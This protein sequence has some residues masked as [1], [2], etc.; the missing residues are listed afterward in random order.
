MTNQEK[1][2]TGNCNSLPGNEGPNC[3]LSSEYYYYLQWWWNG[4]NS[5]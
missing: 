5:L 1:T 4:N 2:M 3:I